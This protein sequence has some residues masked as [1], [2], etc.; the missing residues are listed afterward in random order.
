ML[1]FSF[2]SIWTLF[3]GQFLTEAGLWQLSLAHSKKIKTW[4]MW[5]EWCIQIFK[6]W[7]CFSCFF[8]G[9]MFI[10]CKMLVVDGRMFEKILLGKSISWRVWW[11]P[12]FHLTPLLVLPTTK[13][14]YRHTHRRTL[15]LSL[16]FSF[17]HTHI[18]FFFFSNSVFVFAR[19]GNDDLGCFT[20]FILNRCLF[21]LLCPFT[22]SFLL[23]QISSCYFSTNSTLPVML[24]SNLLSF[25]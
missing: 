12:S 1:T 14:R 16:F 13:T 4:K 3:S 22:Q 17:T 9:K 11:L 19:W 2:S 8:C 5:L 25:S 7:D 6:N 15:S 24:R 10:L 21:P 20:W 23:S 18:L